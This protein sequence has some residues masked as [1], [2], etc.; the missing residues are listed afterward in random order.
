MYKRP[1][2][3]HSH[4]LNH[5]AITCLRRLAIASLE[6]QTPGRVQAYMYAHAVEPQVGLCLWQPN[7][8]TLSCMAVL[9][10]LYLDVGLNNISGTL[11]GSWSNLT[12]ASSIAIA[13]M[14]SSIHVFVKAT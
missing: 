5:A 8:H 11:P 13:F 2:D 12:Q 6:G 10:L 7:A 3:F 1:L 9:Q 14:L 4:C